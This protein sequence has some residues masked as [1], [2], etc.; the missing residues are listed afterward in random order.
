MSLSDRERAILD[1]ERTWWR[2]PGRKAAVIRERFGFSATRYYEM[3]NDLLKNP[4]AMAYDP[5]VVRRLRRDRD[6]RRRARFAGS[7][8]ASEES[9]T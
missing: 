4:H 5:L 2:I 3:L 6:R 9:R 7:G 1:Y 8:T